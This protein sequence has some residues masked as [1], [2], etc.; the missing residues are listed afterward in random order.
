MIATLIGLAIRHGYSLALWRLPADDLITL[1]ISR[2][3]T[4]L[5]QQEPLESLRPGFLFA[6]FDHSLDRIYLPADIFFSFRNGTLNRPVSESEVASVAWLQS[7]LKNNLTPTNAFYKVAFSESEME[8]EEFI[9]LI[10]EAIREIGELQLQKIV[11]SR[12]DVIDI[13]SKFEVIAAFDMLCAANPGALVSFVTTPASGSWIGAT[14]EMLVTVENNIFRTVALAGTQRYEAG[15]NLRA[16][17]WTQKDIEEQA[18]VERYIIS[19]FKM[20][21]LREYEEHG[22]KTVVAGSL[23]HLKSE[24]KV[25]MQATDFP[26]LGTVMLKLLHPTSAV[27]GSPLPAALRFLKRYEKYERQFYT[28]YLGPVNV[29]GEVHLYVNLRCAQ[30][31]EGKA[32]LYA[33]AGITADSNPEQEWEETEIK[34]QTLRGILSGSLL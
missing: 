26:Q 6:P 11:P 29:N 1:I 7:E 28:G 34:M 17:A 12:I 27:C 23:L 22:P 10:G 4:W 21:R 20:I 30:L 25:D 19:C 3:H 33:G 24:F 2:R 31:I 14:P 13:D 5:K 8:K 15:Q 16:V 18:L 32:V 9:S